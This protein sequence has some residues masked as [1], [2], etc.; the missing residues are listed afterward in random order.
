MTLALLSGLKSLIATLPPVGCTPPAIS[1]GASGL[2]G[3]C[4]CEAGS[5]QAQGK[6]TWETGG[7]ARMEEAF[8][9]EQQDT[10]SPA[11]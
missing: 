4:F 3:I 2:P 6:H 5:P 7:G 10:C 1:K 9:T 11:L 8:Q